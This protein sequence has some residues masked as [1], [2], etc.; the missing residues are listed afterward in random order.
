M[1]SDII[2]ATMPMFIIWRL[3]R[4]RIEKTLITILMTSSLIAS[5][6]GI[7]KIYY[8]KTFVLDTDDFLWEMTPE[9]LWNRIEEITIF[10]AACAPLLKAPIEQ[11]LGQLG[12]PIF[13]NTPRELNVLSSGPCNSD[14]Q[15]T[16]RQLS[17]GSALWVEGRSANKTIPVRVTGGLAAVL[18]RLDRSP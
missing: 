17:G 12:L 5:G 4:S 13:H 6:V 8:M 10:I 9:F 2:C 11:V 7:A 14:Q 3:S 18:K 1:L 15:P 16:R